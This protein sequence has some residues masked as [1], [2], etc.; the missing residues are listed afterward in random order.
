[1]KNIEEPTRAAKALGFR[2]MFED[3]DNQAT[4]ESATP[5]LP[6]PALPRAQTT[7]RTPQPRR[8]PPP[9]RGEAPELKGSTE[10]TSAEM[11]ILLELNSI[12]MNLTIIQKF[13]N[14]KI[15]FNSF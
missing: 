1:M 9:R 11:E 13:K 3:C 5:T 12:N 4:C 10:V 6:S 15:I 14:C 7:G 8:P 2:K